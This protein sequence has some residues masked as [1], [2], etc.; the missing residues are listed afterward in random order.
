LAFAADP[1]VRAGPYGTFFYSFIA[2]NRDSAAGGVTA[3]QRFIDR[4][5]NIAVGSDPIRP[6][7]VNV[8]DVG[9]VGQFKDKPWNIADVPGRSWNAGATCIIPGYNLDLDPNTHLPKLGTE[10]PVP[11]FNVY[12]S[13]ANFVGQADKNAHP[14]VL[15]ARSTDCGQTFG[16]P[17][18]L[19]NSIQ[20]NQGTSIAIDPQTGGVYVFWRVVG[21]PSVGTSDAIYMSASTDGGNSWSN[22]PI[23]VSNIIPF[24]QVST[25]A[26]F[27]T[28]AFPAST[29]S[30]DTN[31]VTRLHVAWAQRHGTININAGI[32][33]VT[34]VFN[35]A[36]VGC[37]FSP[38]YT[39]CDAHIAMKTLTLPSANYAWP[40][41]FVF[42]DDSFADP[43]GPG[44]TNAGRGHQ[45]MPSLAFSGGKVAAMWYDQRL[46]HTQSQ[47][48]CPVGT[49]CTSSI[50]FV[51][52]IV[53]VGN[54]GGG[55]ASEK[56]LFNP[57][58][59]D[60]PAASITDPPPGLD[61]NTRLVRRHTIDVFATLAD[62]GDVPAFSPS[63]RVSQYL[64]GNLRDGTGA[65]ATIKQQ[66]QNPPNIPIA[67]SGRNAFIG[68]YT[69]M[70]ARTIVATRNGSQ[71]YRFD[72]GPAV[73]SQFCADTTSATTQP[74]FYPAWTDN[75]D[76]VRPANGVWTNHT[77]IM[78]ATSD[79][80][81]NIQSL[82]TNASCVSGQ[83]GSRNSN[84]YVA[85]I[86]KNA[87]PLV[88][89]NSKYLTSAAPRGFVVG[90]QNLAYASTADDGY[91]SFCLTI[92]NTPS[93]PVPGK[94]SFFQDFSDLKPPSNAPSSITVTVPPRS[95]AA[96][97]AWLQSTTDTDPNARAA[98]AVG[99]SAG[100][101]PAPPQPP[102]SATVASLLLNPDPA[103]TLVLN[104]SP[105]GTPDTVNY[106]YLSSY[107][108]PT[109]GT[110][111]TISVSTLQFSTNSLS[112]NSL[113]TNAI[114]S[115]SLSTVALSSVTVINTDV[116]NDPLLVNSLS[117]NSL[118]TQVLTNDALNALSTNALS[119]NSLSTDSFTN[120]DITDNSLST[121]SLT[122][123]A[124]STNALSTNALST[125]ALSTNALSTNSLSTSA[126]V[127]ASYTVTTAPTTTTA[128]PTNTDTTVDVKS[129][130]RNKA[131]PTGYLAQLVAH[132]KILIP[133][134]V[135]SCKI[136]LLQQSPQLVNLQMPVDAGNDPNDTSKLGQFP[137]ND[138]LAGTLPLYAGEKAQITMRVVCAGNP[139]DCSA[140]DPQGT[141]AQ[142]FAQT[143][144][145]I[146]AIGNAGAAGASTSA[147]DPL[148]INSLTVTPVVVHKSDTR[149]LTSLGGAL[150]QIKWEI[151]NGPSWITFSNG[152][153][154]TTVTN[155]FNPTT[156]ANGS[157]VTLNINKPPDVGLFTFIFKLSNLTSG[158]VDTEHIV[159]QVTK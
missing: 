148:V 111:A 50:N 150:G 129:L 58:L 36:N 22:Q 116:A 107:T 118:S 39:N 90:V 2:G 14:Q 152:L 112:T 6:D 120:V 77:S 10:K 74:V 18:K 41:N 8:I 63:A 86:S 131:L 13:Y 52:K 38:G 73:A 133:T 42:I 20:T 134:S 99:I 51:E 54:R 142:T 144:Q 96:R 71:Q 141:A 130:L 91:R 114:S 88:Y 66:Q 109:D 79:A 15:V 104:S 33:P 123:N 3:I 70:A 76:I 158:E 155:A 119:T 97:T 89:G 113:S 105:F 125:N 143:S 132:K 110:Q 151:L 27:R 83:D 65:K 53:R 44:G 11:A 124:L 103:A 19:S 93:G 80:N 24:D 40:A 23:L 78:Q 5:D 31:G 98:V 60:L 30:V 16:K 157:A 75:R 85:A 9:T 156:A 64:Y 17:V 139:T 101:C 159:V 82:S 108:L 1:T 7:V 62:P 48:V 26:S 128:T 25:G 49:T 140:N 127:D 149:T 95:I 4:D 145:K 45:F 154:N 61:V 12:I 57:V 84:V 94:A 55:V 92:N 35:P 28:I 126:L 68:D 117:T 32:D 121:N 67:N 59:F 21:D 137:V 29:A 87:V 56:I 43:T 115:N 46:D 153:L 146:V 47:L 72:C 136:G 102:P 138:R 81:G 135:A 69:D 34:G 122:S 100:A 147:S 37:T 106:N